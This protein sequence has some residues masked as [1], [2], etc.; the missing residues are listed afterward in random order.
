MVNSLGCLKNEN[1]HCDKAEKKKTITKNTHPSFLLTYLTNFISVPHALTYIKLN[2]C[3][4]FFV[5]F[6]GDF[7][8]PEFLI[9]VQT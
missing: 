7:Y 1:P 4:Y 3:W 9:T 8:I 5:Y 2:Y 6:L